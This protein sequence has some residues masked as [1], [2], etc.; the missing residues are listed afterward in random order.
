M[1]LRLSLGAIAALLLA[2]VACQPDESGS[3]GGSG[4]IGGAPT[5]A[6]TCAAAIATGLASCEGLSGEPL[7]AD[8]RACAAE[9]ACADEC[10]AF[11][12][13]TGAAG[14]A[15][16]ACLREACKPELDVCLNDV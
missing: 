4:G 9:P 8:L 12:G 1:R 7:A 15:C 14:E 10:A 2:L 5:C 16:V 6:D 3:G 13:A 11:T